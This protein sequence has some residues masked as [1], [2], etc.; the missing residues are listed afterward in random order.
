MKKGAVVGLLLLIITSIFIFSSVNPTGFV[1]YPS[2]GT[3]MGE[4]GVI[5]APGLYTFD[6]NIVGGY[7][8]CIN[9]TSDNVIIDAGNSI[10]E[11][12]SDWCYGIYAKNQ[13][14]ITI[15]NIQFNEPTLPTALSTRAFIGIY[16][17]NVSDSSLTDITARGNASNKDIIYPIILSDSDNNEVIGCD[18]NDT[19]VGVY[20][21]KSSNN[22][23]LDNNISN[24]GSAIGLSASANEITTENIIQNNR[25]ID[26]KKGL[27]SFFSSG[28]GLI[29][30]EIVDNTIIGSKEVG[31]DLNNMRNNTVMSNIITD[32]RMGLKVTGGENNR[33]LHNVLSDN[34]Y[35]LDISGAPTKHTWENNTMQGYKMYDSLLLNLNSATVDGMGGN[36][37]AVIYIENCFNS[38]IKNMD[39]SPGR[40]TGFIIGDTDSCIFENITANIYIN[41]EAKN[42]NFTFITANNGSQDG[43]Y[44]NKSTSNYFQVIRASANLGS[45]IYFGDDS[46]NNVF[47]STAVAID[48]KE[49]GIRIGGSNNVIAGATSSNGLTGFRLGNTYPGKGLPRA[50]PSTNN[51]ITSLITNENGGDGLRLYV[52]QNNI[53]SNVNANNNTGIGISLGNLSGGNQFDK[54]TANHNK[55]GMRLRHDTSGNT[56]TNSVFNDNINRGIFVKGATY[57]NNYINCT[58]KRNNIGIHFYAASDSNARDSV[59]IDNTLADIKTEYS[60]LN[61]FYD[62]NYNIVDIITV[63]SILHRG[64]TATAHF[65]EYETLRIAVKNATDGQP[66]EFASISGYYPNNTKAFTMSTNQNGTASWDILVYEITPDNPTGLRYNYTLEIAKTGYTPL[67]INLTDLPPTKIILINDSG[68]F[69]DTVVPIVTLD[70]PIGKKIY[71]DTN[72]ISFQVEAVD[73]VALASCGLYTDL[74]VQFKLYGAK[75]LSGNIDNATWKINNMSEGDHIWNVKC[76]DVTGNCAFALA[77]ES[78]T[79]NTKQAGDDDE[80]SSS[81]SSHRRRGKQ[82]TFSISSTEKLGGSSQGGLDDKDRIIFYIRNEQRE[83]EEHVLTVVD[84]NRGSVE[85]KITSITIDAEIFVGDSE[86]YDLTGDKSPDVRVT[87]DEIDSNRAKITIETGFV[88]PEDA[89]QETITPEEQIAQ[90]LDGEGQLVDDAE[91]PRSLTWLWILLAIIIVIIVGVVIGLIIKN[92][93]EKEMRAEGMEE[94][95]ETKTEK[96][97]TKTTTATEKAKPKTP[98]KKK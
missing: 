7:G 33:F 30:N 8:A 10:I 37:A 68:I 65:K 54:I 41:G 21:I 72:N 64:I 26:N 18:F 78:Y 88:K 57:F 80:G 79:I 39:L 4:C 93:K 50:A 84:V 35:N 20:L 40:S 77:N 82:Y 13:K 96:A 95:T 86:E 11:C 62:V 66:I 56:I 23:I 63:I 59:F 42:N 76:C 75:T 6:N 83:L 9:I 85:V 15:K 55:E 36:D 2:D 60:T 90:G 69:I 53:I 1:V 17:I 49:Y 91:K 5:N 58:A 12:T 89:P 25:L 92:Q 16:F 14:N 47:A 71:E 32:G 87:L 67:T 51:N 22:R 46:N 52:A 29:K 43:I 3:D 74:N 28:L 98:Q 27:S 19:S 73:D 24:S 48:N 97:V 61:K 44:I 31:I 70:G 94:V 45:G 34:T 81:S 38:T